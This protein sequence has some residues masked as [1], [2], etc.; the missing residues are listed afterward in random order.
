MIKKNLAVIVILFALASCSSTKKT[1][2]TMP[3]LY[4]TWDL[5]ILNGDSVSLFARQPTIQFNDSALKIAGNG[6]CNN[7]FSNYSKDGNKISFAPIASTKMA[8]PGM[9]EIEVRYFQALAKV[10]GYKF[11]NGEL[12]LLNNGKTIAIFKE[13]SAAPDNLT[14]KW[15]LYYIDGRKISF[16]GLYPDKKP[17][18]TFEQGS[19]YVSA[20]TGCNALSSEFNTKKGL[21]FKPGAMTLMACPGEGEQVFME[22]FKKVNRYEVS[23]DTL[24]FFEN[25]TPVMKFVKMEN[26]TNS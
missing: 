16:D 11:E 15:K 2:E 24:T 6:G 23:G 20:F 1:T 22:Y 12:H 26:E 8:C 25:K 5:K 14:G 10:T 19:S 21:L 13:S 9:D 7:F 4:Q 18:I 17:T 3:S